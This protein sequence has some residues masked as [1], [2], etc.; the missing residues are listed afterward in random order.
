MARGPIMLWR[1]PFHMADVDGL[2]PVEILHLAPA[3][4]RRPHGADLSLVAD[5]DVIARPDLGRRIHDADR[6]DI[7]FGLEVFDLDPVRIGTG[8]DFASVQRQREEAPTRVH[9]HLLAMAH[10]AD[11][12]ETTAA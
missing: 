6:E 10:D 5:H 2:A 1:Q 11:V 9:G 3:E 12:R 8:E 4:P 7:A